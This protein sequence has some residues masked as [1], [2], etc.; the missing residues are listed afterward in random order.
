MD[1]FI[2]LLNCF[3]ISWWRL[4]QNIILRSLVR[5]EEFILKQLCACLRFF[6]HLLLDRKRNSREIFFFEPRLIFMRLEKDP[7]LSLLI[8][9]LIAIIGRFQLFRLMFV[10]L[11]VGHKIIEA[12]ERTGERRDEDS[13]L[14]RT[15]MVPVITRICRIRTPSTSGR[16]SP[17]LFEWVLRLTP[18]SGS[19][20]FRRVGA[21]G[22][23]IKIEK[24]Y[25][26]LFWLYGRQLLS[27][28][29][30]LRT[31]PMMSRHAL[32]LLGCL[33]PS[34]SFEV[35]IWRGNTVWSEESWD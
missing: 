34:K 23:K 12:D 16:I 19:W 13:G 28:S 35:N 1:L 20:L 24:T 17:F 2:Q 27:L 7:L 25:L 9:S 8:V 31:I 26:G 30:S 6:L 29:P 15:A 11:L 22:L 5:A 33:V 21:F 3:R 14:A 18:F 32:S 4:Q 10:R